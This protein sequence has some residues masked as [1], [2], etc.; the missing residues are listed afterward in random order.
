MLAA[1][2]EST[3]HDVYPINRGY[4]NLQQRLT[5]IGASIDSVE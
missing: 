5:A 2:G 4:E 3:G 1:E